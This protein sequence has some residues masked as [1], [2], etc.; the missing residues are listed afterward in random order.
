MADYDSSSASDETSERGLSEGVSSDSGLSDELGGGSRRQ[1][2]FG[3]DRRAAKAATTL[4]TKV[5]ALCSMCDAER[6][7]Y[8]CESCGRLTF[9]LKCCVSLHDNRF[10]GGHHVESMSDNSEVTVTV[11]RELLKQKAT[12]A[13]QSKSIVN[14]E[15]EEPKAK[16]PGRHH[17]ESESVSPQR[18]TMDDDLDHP[19]MAAD[20]SVIQARLKE[21]TNCSD[22]LR[23]IGVELSQEIDISRETTS[24]AVEAVKRKFDILRSVIAAKEAE[25]VSVVQD[26]GRSRLEAATKGQTDANVVVSE[27]QGFVAHTENQLDRLQGNRRLFNTSRRSLLE[28]SQAKLSDA[29]D[30]IHRLQDRLDAVRHHSLGMHISLEDAVEALQRLQPPNELTSRRYDPPHTEPVPGSKFVESPGVKTFKQHAPLAPSRFTTQQEPQRQ[31]FAKEVEALRQSPLPQQRTSSP[32]RKPPSA[33]PTQTMDTSTLSRQKDGSSLIARTAARRHSPTRT[34]S[35]FPPELEALRK[36]VSGNRSLGSTTPSRTNSPMKRRAAT[37]TR[38][39]ADSPMKEPSGRASV[40]NNPG[41]GAYYQPKPF[42]AR[43][44]LSTPPRRR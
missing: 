29:D 1:M 37:P 4:S 7:T 28:T 43:S 10:L 31:S 15:E 3:N 40:D 22:S 36:Q 19:G 5:S 42:G 41:P 20:Q 38:S 44:V 12:P 24:T 34:R 39:A 30:A 6:S 21:I 35:L 26:A 8:L 16:S 27:L 17:S 2:N 18:V 33:P 23:K 25:F 32:I 9:C 11:L 14:V 13:V